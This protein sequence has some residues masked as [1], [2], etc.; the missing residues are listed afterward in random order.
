MDGMPVFNLVRETL[1]AVAIA[2]L[3]RHRQQHDELHPDRDGTRAS[4]STPRSP[5]CRRAALPKPMPSLDIDGWDAA[6]K[7][8][9]LANV[10]LDARITPHDVEREGIAPDVGAAGAVRRAPPGGG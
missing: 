6:A 1:P 7:T 10:L 8:A 2:R 5:R 9:A 4:R 3:S